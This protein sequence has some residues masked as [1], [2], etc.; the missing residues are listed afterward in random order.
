MQTAHSSQ[1]SIT[2]LPVGSAL[3][4]VEHGPTGLT[5][6]RWLGAGGMATVYLAEH[7]GKTFVPPLSADV[8]K[9][10]A[11][12]LMHAGIARMLKKNGFDA[13][14]LVDRERLA[15]TRVMRDVPPPDNVIGFYGAGTF[16]FPGPHGA[17]LLP[18]LAL[19]YVDGGLAGATLLDRMRAAPQGLD[20][21]RVSQIAEQVLK[22]AESLHRHRVIHRDIKPE[23]VFMAGPTD[24]ETV[25]LGDC[26]IARVEGATL[27]TIP[28]MSPQ[29][30]AP[31]QYLSQLEPTERNPLIGPWT[32]VH[33]LA[34]LVWF[35]ITGEDWR[36]SSADLRWREGY[37][38]AVETGEKVVSV[39]PTAS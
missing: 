30:A 23:N 25:K 5:L 15:L 8:P 10:V 27:P 39:Q 29:Y 2:S 12:K 7:D 22:G 17:E 18:W 6:K 14:A 1:P 9:W 37:R 33:A 36:T 4:D 35:T 28:A 26:G 19:E 32:D 34:A 16:T 38:R 11:V 24:D 13:R 3:V 21:I 31:E 20:P